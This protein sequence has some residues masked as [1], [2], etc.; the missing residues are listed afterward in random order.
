[1]KDS[2]PE[3]TEVNIEVLRSVLKKFDTDMHNYNDELSKTRLGKVLTIIDGA[4][5]D[6]TQRKAVKDL[7]N[8]SWYSALDS[9]RYSYPKLYKATEALG[10]RLWNETAVPLAP[11]DY[12]PYEEI[13]KNSK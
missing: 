10:F 5:A 2:S 3:V 13:V 8:D 4:I 11:E 6:E 12:N 9:R 7:I 1:M